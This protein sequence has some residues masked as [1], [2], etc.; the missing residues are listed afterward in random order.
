MEELWRRCGA[1]AAAAQTLSLIVPVGMFAG[2]GKYRG[3]GDAEGFEI[4]GEG[5]SEEQMEG[6]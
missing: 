3:V 6:R 2:V 1:A 4:E 5:T